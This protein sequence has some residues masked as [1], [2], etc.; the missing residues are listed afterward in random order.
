M[1]LISKKFGQGTLI[2]EEDG[3]AIIQFESGIKTVLIQFA[4]LTKEDGTKYEATTLVPETKITKTRKISEKSVTKEH[5][6]EYKTLIIWLLNNKCNYKG[7]LN[8]KQTMQTLLSKVENNEIKYKT[9]KGIKGVIT[10]ETLHTGL[11]NSETNLRAANGFDILTLTNGNSI[12]EAFQ[13]Y[14]LTILN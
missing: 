4:G 12:L 11:A 2:S 7:Y 5:L 10:R 9:L 8:L 6:T 1:K 13:S 14:K 3:R